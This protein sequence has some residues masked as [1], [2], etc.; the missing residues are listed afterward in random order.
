MVKVTRPGRRTSV[1]GHSALAACVL[2]QPCSPQLMAQMGWAFNEPFEF[3][4]FTLT[5]NGA[6]L[7]DIG[8]NHSR[9]GIQA[10]VLLTWMQCR[11]GHG[12]CANITMPAAEKALCCNSGCKP[13]PSPLIGPLRSHT[14]QVD[15]EY[16]HN[17]HRYNV[18]IPGDTPD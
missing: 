15:G 9:Y 1:L 11:L 10:L 13:C 7:P 6:A 14:V 2:L 5:Y 3:P 4:G 8:A 16:R 18:H 12:C 17:S